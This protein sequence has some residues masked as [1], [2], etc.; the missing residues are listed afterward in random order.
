MEND[1]RW[2]DLDSNR[3]SAF[4]MSYPRDILDRARRGDVIL[5]RPSP[6]NEELDHYNDRPPVPSPRI[7]MVQTT[8]DPQ[9][10]EIARHVYVRDI[11]DLVTRPV[12]YETIE[13]YSHRL[14]QQ[15][16]ITRTAVA[17]AS[18]IG[19][20]L[21]NYLHEYN[22]VFHEPSDNAIRQILWEGRSGCLNSDCEEGLT[23]R[24]TVYAR[25][26]DFAE[27]ISSDTISRLQDLGVSNSDL[28]LCPDC[29]GYQAVLQQERAF[30]SFLFGLLPPRSQLQSIFYSLS[31]LRAELGY[32]PISR[33]TFFR[34]AQ[35]VITSY[36]PRESSAARA[37]FEGQSS[38][39]TTLGNDFRAL[40]PPT[41]AGTSR[42]QS[43]T[44]SRS[45]TGSEPSNGVTLISRI[46]G[47][48]LEP[49]L[50]PDEL[51]PTDRFPNGIEFN[52]NTMIARRPVSLAIWL[53]LPKLS[54]A[55]FD[56]D[57]EVLDENCPICFERLGECAEGA[58]IVR[59]SC[60]HLGHENCLGSWLKDQDSCPKCRRRVEEV[61][62]DDLE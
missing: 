58:R 40:G 39:P 23:S 9:I 53:S 4:E 2:T 43:A 45:R 29:H 35:A 19:T 61:R 59:L 12:H 17:A 54:L 57:D 55:Q 18:G 8:A 30:G 44:A 62:T 16:S 24:A 46:S 36:P 48:S 1:K 21:T 13:E 56:P 14:H 47:L 15:L 7:L 50:V 42:N 32:R 60:R 25:Y 51:S 41:S 37:M 3:K 33:D 52:P 11:T 10:G 31:R 49:V 20:S 26:D 27:D 28:M 38:T 34:S 6:Y 5:V 22:I